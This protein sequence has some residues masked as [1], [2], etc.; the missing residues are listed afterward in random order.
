MLNQAHHHHL[1][2]PWLKRIMS[3]PGRHVLHLLIL[4]ANSAG[5]AVMVLNPTERRNKV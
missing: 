1:S 5:G 4:G 3:E 2:L